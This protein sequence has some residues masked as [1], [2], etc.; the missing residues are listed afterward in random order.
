MSATG[1]ASGS[2]INITPEEWLDRMRGYFYGTLLEISKRTRYSTQGED[3]TVKEIDQFIEEDV[4]TQ[5]QKCEHVFFCVIKYLYIECSEGAERYMEIEGL[6][7]LKKV[8]QQGEEEVDQTDET[9]TD[10][11]N[12][13]S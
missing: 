10:L 1:V 6:N 7:A 11:E 4:A 12:V 5:I 8:P 9:C 3:V 13:D 2:V